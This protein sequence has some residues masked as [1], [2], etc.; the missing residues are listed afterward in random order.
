[1]RITKKQR[2]VL[3]VICQ[4]LRDSKNRRVGWLDAQQIC[5]RVPYEVSIHSM[6]FTIRFLGQKGLAEKSDPVLRRERWVVPVKPTNEAFDYIVSR[7]SM[8]E[9]EHD[10]DVVELYL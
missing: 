5:D 9:V 1:V 10:N 3:E 6:K 7:A 4:G 8:R 2:Q